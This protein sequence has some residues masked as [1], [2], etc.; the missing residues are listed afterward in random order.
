MYGSSASKGYGSGGKLCVIG[1]ISFGSARA[2]AQGNRA[3]EALVGG[4]GR[5][6]IGR[7]SGTNL[8][9]GGGYIEDLGY[10][11]NVSVNLGLVDDV[12][13]RAHIIVTDMP[14]N[15]A[16]GVRLVAEAG[17]R[18]T[19]WFEFVGLVGYDIRDINHTGISL[20]LGTT[21]LW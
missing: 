20:G 2:Y 15:E 18:A 21:F 19:S 3:P 13:L 5:I 10:E 17:W 7:P 14:V 6:R 4:G 8:E 1:R 11:A 9:L 12:P 16:L